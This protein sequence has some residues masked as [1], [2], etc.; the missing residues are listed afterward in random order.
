VVRGLSGQGEQV[1]DSIWDNEINLANNNE[2][3]HYALVHMKKLLSNM[4]TRRFD[5]SLPVSA[6]YLVKNNNRNNNDS[7]AGY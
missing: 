7:Q 4:Q 1:H 6:N 5:E 2:K 3:L